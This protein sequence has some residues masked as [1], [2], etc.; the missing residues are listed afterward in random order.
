MTF[1]QQLWLILAGIWTVLE[2]LVGYKTR[3]SFHD[4]VPQLKNYQKEHLIWL[5]VVISIIG[6][7]GFKHLQLVQLPMS[8]GVRQIIALIMMSIGLMIRFYAI[9]RLG[10]FFSTT[11]VIQNEHA[12]ITHGL[13]QFIRHPAYTGL[14][15]SFFAIGVAMGDILAILILVLPL[16]LFLK[17]RIS[18]EEDIL[19]GHFGKD[20][21]EYAVRTKKLIPWLY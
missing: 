9:K 3:V 17:Q 4:S 10:R 13:Y 8:Y 15:I 14:L 6:A 19:I 11:V 5:V 12:L 21:L 16:G 18:V 2:I 1:I 7:F 20:Y